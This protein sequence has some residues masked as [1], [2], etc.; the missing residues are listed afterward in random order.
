LRVLG[1]EIHGYTSDLSSA[2][3]RVISTMAF[4]VAT[5]MSLQF[6]FGGETCY[7]QIV[8]Q[9]VFCGKAREESRAKYEIGIKLSAVR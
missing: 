2:G 9:V 4:S 7:A 6:C 1:K 3:L 5:P 8:G